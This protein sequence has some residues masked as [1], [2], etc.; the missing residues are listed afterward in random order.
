MI[1]LALMIVDGVD[2]VDGHGSAEP[3]PTGKHRIEN[4][5]L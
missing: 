4:W 2:D 1:G 3:R 5:S